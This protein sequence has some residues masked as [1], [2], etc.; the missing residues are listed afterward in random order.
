MICDPLG[1]DASHGATERAVYAEHTAAVL[2]RRCAEQAKT[3]A[4][5]LAKH[6]PAP[7]PAEHPIHAAIAVMQRQGVR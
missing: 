6:E 7:A 1:P 2:A 3:I 5:L 4:A